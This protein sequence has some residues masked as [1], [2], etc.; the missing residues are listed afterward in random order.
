MQATYIRSISL[1][2][3][4]T[5]E[6]FSNPKFVEN[7]PHNIAKTICPSFTYDPKCIKIHSIQTSTPKF[8]TQCQ[9]PNPQFATIVNQ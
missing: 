3:S 7:S 6:K 2:D 8:P 1:H 9:T 5:F 4:A